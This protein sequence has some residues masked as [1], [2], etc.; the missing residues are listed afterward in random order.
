MRLTGE[1]ITKPPVNLMI[2]ALGSE[3]REGCGPEGGAVAVT[4]RGPSGGD[5]MTPTPPAAEDVQS[6]RPREV[7]ADT[8]PAGRG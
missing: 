4:R 7:L 6:P 1:W 8:V 5:G 3:G 2:S